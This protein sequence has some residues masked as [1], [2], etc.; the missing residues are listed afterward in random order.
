MS[1]IKAGFAMCGS[2]CTFSK[3]LPEMKALAEKGVEVFPIMS[4]TSFSTDTRFGEAK[5]FTEEIEKICSKKIISTICDAEPI[6]PKKMLDILI[7]APCTGNTIAKIAN[8]IADTPVTLAVK[9][10]LRN[11][12]PV[13]IGIS[14]NDALGAN[15]KNIGVLLNCKNIFFIPFRQDD[16]HK[17]P[18]SI[19]ADFTKIYPAMTKA[20]EKIQIQPM[21]TE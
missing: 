15:A 9:A 18:R 2:F 13:L 7:V 8:G 6:G 20:L 1:S 19:V 3:I 10:H 11:E 17:K 16:P 4:D 5:Y 21:I 12:R 14:S